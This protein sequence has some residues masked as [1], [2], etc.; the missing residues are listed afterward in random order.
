MSLRNQDGKRITNSPNACRACSPTVPSRART[1]AR[2]S[3][4]PSLPDFPEGQPEPAST[5]LLFLGGGA[6]FP[7]LGGIPTMA[8]RVPCSTVCPGTGAALK[9]FHPRTLPLEASIVPTPPPHKMLWREDRLPNGDVL[10][11]IHQSQPPPSSQS[12]ALT[13]TR[14][15]APAAANQLT[16][17]STLH[18]VH[19]CPVYRSLPRTVPDSLVLLTCLYL[20]SSF[21][22]ILQCFS[23]NPPTLLPLILGLL[24]SIY[25]A[26]IDCQLSAS[27]LKDWFQYSHSPAI[28]LHDLP[29]AAFQ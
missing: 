7:C 8:S 20:P 4:V 6:G 10:S 2:S 23:C 16:F 9:D 3:R 21:L 17:I 13:H 15:P 29:S 27:F 22:P 18:P 25:P 26:N 12:P 19:H 24:C 1:G 14:S 11:G 28:A 5:S